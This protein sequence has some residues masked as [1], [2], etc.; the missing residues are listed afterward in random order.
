MRLGAEL[1]DFAGEA[2]CGGAEVDATPPQQVP[3]LFKVV[4]PVDGVAKRVERTQEDVALL[5][6]KL[7]GA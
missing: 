5:L 6:L 7:C 4:G 2:V 3:R 1:A